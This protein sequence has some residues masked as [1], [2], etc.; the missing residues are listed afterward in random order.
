MSFGISVGDILKL[1]EMAGRVYKNCRDCTGEYKSFTGE[2]RSLANL[3]EDIQ[4]KYDKIPESKRQQLVDAYEP[5]VDV[6]QELDKLLLHYN[7]L[8][9]KAARTWN[10]LK[11]DPERS[12]TLREKLVASVAMLNTFYTSLIHDGQVLILEALGRLERDYR[13]GHREESVASIERIASAESENDDEAWSQ[14][15]RDLEDVG[16][17]QHEALGYRDMIVDWLITAVNEGRLHEQEPEQNMF[18]TMPQ[19]LTT[20][21]SHPQAW[22]KPV[23][24]LLDVPATIPLSQGDHEPHVVGQES[25]LNAPLPGQ[26]NLLRPLMIPL[27]HSAPRSMSPSNASQ[28]SDTDAASLYDSPRISSA[29][30]VHN[31]LRVGQVSVAASTTIPI[32]AGQYLPPDTTAQNP[33]TT[34]VPTQTLPASVTSP[35]EPPPSYYNKIETLTVNF[36][37][38]AQQIVAAW[39]RHDFLSSEKLLEEH[40]AAVEL[41]QTVSSGIQPDRRILRHLIGVCASFTGNFTKAKHMFESSFNGIYLNRGSL[42]DGDIAAARWLGDACLHLGE[43]H[44]A[45]LAYSVACEGSIGRFGISQER[46]RRAGIEVRLLDHWLFVFGRIEGSFRQNLDPTDIFASTHAAEKSDLIHAVETRLYE[47]GELGGNYPGP[48]IT[49]YKRPTWTVGP[50]PQIETM[51]SE[52]FLL[53]PLISLS[54]WPLPWDPTFSPQ[55]A[56]QL[57]RFMNT[58]QIVKDVTPLAERPL[59]TN[60]LGNSRALHYVTKRSS[61]WLIGAVKTGLRV[62]GIEHTEHAYEASIVCC[63][64]RYQDGFAFSEGFEI[65]FRKLQFRNVHGIMISD[66]KWATRN[67]GPIRR[68]VAPPGTTEF[69]DLIKSILEAAEIEESGMG[70]S[71]SLP[72]TP[73]IKKRAMYG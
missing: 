44:N 17:S 71:P 30:S 27:P 48:P 45:L 38:T 2:A 18:S 1:C 62:M 54:T 61:A 60:S 6:L 69:R 58:I 70:T 19:T 11:F 31:E 16:I 10:R 43:H 35:Q 21:L 72:Q 66:M 52:G 13:G 28:I 9:T 26:T 20:A 59:P 47:I 5:C 37:W 65:S 14:I 32:Q 8:D 25:L 42:D 50:R 49:Q 4:D 41:G 68:G 63:L 12:K 39:S 15:L 34:S 67:I 40:L 46:T 22:A 53:A 7:S 24:P 23:S 55:A 73:P 57:G 3:L 36:E 56:V 64:N 33:T 29:Q 51:I